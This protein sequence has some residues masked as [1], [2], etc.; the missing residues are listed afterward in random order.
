MGCW[1]GARERDVESLLSTL[2]P[3]SRIPSLD[4]LRAV[5]FLLV[6]GDHAG[7]GL[8]VPLVAGDLGVTIFFFLSGFIITTLMR[9]EFETSGSVNL[10]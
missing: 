1:P 4:G 6:F 8:A 3:T 5:S 7:L 9:L 2:T 10:R